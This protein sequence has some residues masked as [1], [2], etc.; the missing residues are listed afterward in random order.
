M[1]IFH[2]SDI[3]YNKE[4][5]DGQAKLQRIVESINTQKVKAD[6]VV[7]TG[8]IVWKEHKEY[9][10]ECFDILNGLNAPYLL[11][12]GNHDNSL[13]ISKAVETYLPNHPRAEMEKYFQYVVDKDF[14]RIIGL[15]TYKAGYGGG[16]FDE[17]R[18]NWLIE[19]L[20]EVGEKQQVILLLH[21]Y[22]LPTGSGFFD[23][24]PGAWFIRFNNIVKKY[25]SNIKLILCGHLHN[26]LHS[27]ISGVPIISGFSTNWGE[28][29]LDSKKNTPERDTS[30][31]LSYLIHKVEEG[32]ITTYVVPVR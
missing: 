25:K 26:S 12:S 14:V 23:L 18:E 10:R 1:Y 31:S 8:D 3:H 24:H 7:V 32:R 29:L 17:E 19:K 6:Y 30:R 13:D 27:D 20:N 4:D 28:P 16:E 11:I 9:Y 21:Q 22:T 15:D 2:I 5:T